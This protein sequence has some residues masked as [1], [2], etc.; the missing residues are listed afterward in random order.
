[1]SARAQIRPTLL[2]SDEFTEAAAK[3]GD[4]T[5]FGIANCVCTLPAVGT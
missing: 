3:H 1:M 5:A 2:G 4:T